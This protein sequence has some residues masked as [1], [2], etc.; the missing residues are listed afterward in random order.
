MLI[1]IVWVELKLSNHEVV[2]LGKQKL[3]KTI[4][5]MVGLGNALQAIFSS[6]NATIVGVTNIMEKLP[7]LSILS[8]L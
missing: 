7:K 6:E 3:S 5:G 2:K 8:K 1:S 4:I